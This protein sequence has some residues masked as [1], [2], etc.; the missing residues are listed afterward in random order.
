MKVD[1]PDPDG[2]VSVRNSPRSTFRE[3]PRSARTFA[4]HVRLRQIAC[5]DKRLTHRGSPLIVAPGVAV[6]PPVASTRSTMSP[7]VTGAV[8]IVGALDAPVVR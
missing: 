5:A 8:A 1:F 3:T 7:R 2:P 6:P 4:E